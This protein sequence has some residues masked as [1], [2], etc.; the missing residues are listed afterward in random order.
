MGGGGF[1]VVVLLISNG[2]EKSKEIKLI[3]G[4]HPLS[5]LACFD[6]SESIITEKL[7]VQL[8]LLLILLVRGHMLFI[9]LATYICK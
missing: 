3:F 2:G 6:E 8:L 4:S 1:F 5:K 9:L 7:T